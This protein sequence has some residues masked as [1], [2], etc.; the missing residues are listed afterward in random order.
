MKTF[1]ITGGGSGIGLATARVLVE[2][3]A[4]VVVAGRSPERLAVA[5]QEL[6][7]ETVSRT[8]RR[9]PTSRR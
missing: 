7:V 5:R 4:R 8:C 6:G 3:G 1:L 9:R 2:D